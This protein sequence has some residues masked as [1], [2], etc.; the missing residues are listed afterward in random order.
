MS[1]DVTT[2][3][4]DD[5]KQH[6]GNDVFSLDGAQQVDIYDINGRLVASGVSSIDHMPRGI[7]I[8]RAVIDGQARSMKLVR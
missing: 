4:I 6:S 3:A 2:T 7:Y 5:I 8:V 1:Y